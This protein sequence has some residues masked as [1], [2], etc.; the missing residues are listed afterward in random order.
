MKYVPHAPKHCINF[1]N[2]VP[3]I[4]IT[5]AA[6]LCSRRPVEVLIHSAGSIKSIWVTILIFEDFVN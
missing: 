4:V 6:T 5:V 2:V 3:F 1:S